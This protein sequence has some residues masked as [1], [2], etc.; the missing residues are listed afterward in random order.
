MGLWEVRVEG[1]K[2]Q[3]EG[4]KEEGREEGSGK[5]GAEEGTLLLFGSTS[6]PFSLPP[7]TPICFPPPSPTPVC[8][9]KG[10]E[11]EGAR[12]GGRESRWGERGIE[13]GTGGGRSNQGV[14]CEVGRISK[15]W[16]GS[17]PLTWST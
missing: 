17:H 12:G 1:G 5:V 6:P 13:V 9:R 7:S 15:W 11:K 2:R 16:T 14:G 8:L 4:G 3:L 10:R